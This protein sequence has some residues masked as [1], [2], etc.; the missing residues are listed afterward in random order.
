[1]SGVFSIG[2]EN[3]SIQ[4]TSLIICFQTADFQNSL[5]IFQN[6]T[7][8]LKIFN[9]VALNTLINTCLQKQ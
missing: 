1:M 5:I 6:K 9:P 2:K 4:K 7:A 8:S 3:V